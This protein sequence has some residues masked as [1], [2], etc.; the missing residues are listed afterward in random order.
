[1]LSW[2]EHRRALLVLDNG[3]HVLDN[4]ADLAE[5]LLAG[6]PGITVLV[7]TRARLQLPFEWVFPVTG[8][9][10]DGGAAPTPSPCS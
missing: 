2:L 8:L 7:T 10:L 3:E 6:A 9:S 1:M 5:R 4:V